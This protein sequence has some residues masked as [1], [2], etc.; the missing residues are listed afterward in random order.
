MSAVSAPLPRPAACDGRGRPAPA[1][2]AAAPLSPR[3]AL[4]QMYAYWAPVWAE[5]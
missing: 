4:D 5:L 1:N 2:R 3:E